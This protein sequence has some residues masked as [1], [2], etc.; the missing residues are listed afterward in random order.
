MKKF[1]SAQGKIRTASGFLE[2]CRLSVM[3]LNDYRKGVYKNVPWQLIA[4]F[5][6]AVVYCVIPLDLIPDF[7]PV[8]GWLDDGGMLALFFAVFRNELAA[9]KVWKER[10]KQTGSQA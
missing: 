6:A 5:I 3:M 10:Q 9:Y 8:A 2:N 4:V 7:I 1:R